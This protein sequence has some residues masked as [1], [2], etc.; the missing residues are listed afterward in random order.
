MTTREL[1]RDVK[2]LKNA[3]LNAVA[4]DDYFKEE[5]KLAEELR[6]LY[7]ADTSMRSL[8]AESLR[9]MLRL[10]VR[11]RAVPFHQFGLFIEL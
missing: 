8:S 6:R 5:P 4:S 7:Y 1:N 2:R 9:V 10:N 11:L 3:Y